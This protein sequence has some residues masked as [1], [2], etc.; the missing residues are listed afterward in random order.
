MNLKS[1]LEKSKKYPPEVLVKKAIWK[2][3]TLTQDYLRYIN[4]TIFETELSDDN[5]N[6]KILTKDIEET[7]SDLSWQPVLCK[8]AKDKIIE[9]VDKSKNHIFNLLGSGDVRVDYKLRVKGLEGYRYDTRLS[10]K[11]YLLSKEKI[12]SELEKVFQKFMKYEPIDWQIDFKSGYRW[13]KKPIVN[14]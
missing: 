5:L 8:E 6:I 12:Q 3:F 10:K 11:E 14:L 4:D 13:S 7:Y 1:I 2:G 9:D